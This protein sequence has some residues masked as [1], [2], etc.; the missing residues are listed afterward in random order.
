MT[1]ILLIDDTADQLCGLEAELKKIIQSNEAGVLTWM[2]TSNDIDPVQ[3]LEDYVKK[4][5]VVFVV[6]DYDL[7]G[8]GHLGLTGSTVVDQ[9]QLWAVP[10]G[11]Y[12]RGSRH[13]LPTE[14]SLFEIR[15]PMTASHEKAAYYIASVFRGFS[16]IKR[17]VDELPVMPRSPA[18]GIATLLN[19]PN[20]QSKF[21]LYGTRYSGVNSGLLDRI[22]EMSQ[23]GVVT[24]VERKKLFS[25]VAGH[26]LLNLVLKFPG[27]IVSL[28]ALTSYCAAHDDEADVLAEVFKDCRYEGP[29]CGIDQYFWV[30][31]VDEVI[32]RIGCESGVGDD[33][34]PGEM[35]RA[36]VEK[37][38]NRPLRRHEC[39]RCG[40]QNGG[41]LCPFTQKTVC[42]QDNCSASSNGW[43]PAAAKLS[44]IERSHYDEWAP[45]LGL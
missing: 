21:A 9:C 14:P 34:G 43:I 42:L 41:F 15:I 24:D 4:N 32:E 18:A 7:T 23:D 17:L 37:I 29:F 13:R 45:L 40:G 25:Y 19:R 22:A 36:A 39:E 38:I 20:D 33:A 12:S 10:V 26:V 27:P 5:E 35:N 30:D 16:S 31:E 44:R 3:I 1:N 8:Q 6:T 28:K 11:D 2:P